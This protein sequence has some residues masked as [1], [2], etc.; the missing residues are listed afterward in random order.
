MNIFTAYK[1]IATMKKLLLLLLVLHG[2]LLHSQGY[3]LINGIIIC[4]NNVVPN[5]MITNLINEKS[6]ISDQNGNFVI[7]ANADDM[8]VFS[9]INYEYHRLLI[10]QE[11]IVTGKITVKL[12]K[13]I[14]QL[15]EVVITNKIKLDAVQL[16][17]LPKPA[18]EYTVA[19]RRLR[20][21]TTGGGFIPLDPIINLITGRTKNLKKQLAVE[22]KEMLLEKIKNLYNDSFY[23]DKLKINASLIKSFQY[24]AVEDDL[25]TTAVESKNR[26]KINFKMMQLAQEFNN[27]QTITQ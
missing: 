19:E 15:D 17:V 5:I 18:K 26:F 9:S 11:D 10:E 21:A 23:I 8:L 20:T 7:A 12:I 2:T 13:K 14:E 27:L 25:L 22:K 16:G 3:N 4:N 6:T 24:Y 1:N